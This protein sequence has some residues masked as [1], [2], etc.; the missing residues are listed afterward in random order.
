MIRPVSDQLFVAVESL[1][2]QLGTF[3][4]RFGAGE[5][6]EFAEERVVAVNRRGPIGRSDGSD[7]VSLPSLEADEHLVIPGLTQ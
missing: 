1:L 7:R 4:R 5:R 3:L 2:R 6:R